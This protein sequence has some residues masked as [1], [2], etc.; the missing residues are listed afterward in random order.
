MYR[1]KSARVFF[2]LLFVHLVVFNRSIAQDWSQV[3]PEVQKSNV[4]VSVDKGFFNSSL[5]SGVLVTREIVGSDGSKRKYNF[6]ITCSHVI[7]DLKQ[8]VVVP[9]GSPV[10]YRWLDADILKVGTN[11]DGSESILKLKARLLTHSGAENGHDLAV[12]MVL[13]DTIIDT[14]TVFHLGPDTHVVGQ[15]VLHVGSPRGQHH[16]VTIGIVSFVGRCLDLGGIR[17]F[18]QICV[19]ALPGSSGGGIYSINGEY[20]GMLVRQVNENFNLMVPMRR[21][22]VWS[23]ENNL[24]WIFDPSISPPS[25]DE[26]NKI[27]PTN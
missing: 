21:I 17:C 20:I 27:T 5:G 16:S 24:Q 2:A 11:L 6:V 7:D 4:T 19:S 26:I 10:I 25:L 8:I 22:H 15:S 12:L 1:F 9:E 13:G 23:E 18:D 3:A 14:N